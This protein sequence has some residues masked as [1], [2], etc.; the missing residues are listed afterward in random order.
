MR[1]RPIRRLR[2]LWRLYVPD[3]VRK[4]WDWF[5]EPVIALGLVLVATT[6]IARP[7]YVPS[8]S[9]EPTLQIGDEFFVSKY[10]YGYSRYSVPFAL[11]P[12]S[13]HRLLERAP[14]RGDII[15]FHMRFPD[16]RDETL[17]KRLIGLP[18]DRVQMIAGRLWIDGRKLPVAPAGAGQVEDDLGE[19]MTVPQYI[20]TLPGGVKHPIFKWLAGGDYDNTQIFTV[21][22]GHYFMMGDDRD[23]SLDSRAPLAV[24]GVGFVPAEDLIGRAEFILGSVDY[25]N[26]SGV[27]AWPSQ[28][29]LARFFK[30]V[31]AR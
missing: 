19:M 16:G 25:K 2:A 8:G 20:E 21:P 3:P 1:S 31:R 18:G 15:A 24:N 10:A 29:R 6:A 14:A 11:G 5:K 7:Y 27:W 12:A 22:S 4:T 9:M 13:Q 23:N 26:A 17:V 30:D 28:L